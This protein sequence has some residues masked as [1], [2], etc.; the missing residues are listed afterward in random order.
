M[1]VCGWFTPWKKSSDKPRQCIKKQRCHF[2]NKGLYSPSYG[3]SIVL[4]RRE[5]LTIKKAE[6]WRTDALGQLGDQTLK[7]VNLE[8]WCWSWS[9]ET[10]ATW[11]EDLTH[12]NRPWCWERLKA[13]GEGAIEEDK[14]VEWH[15]WLNRRKS[16][17][18]PG[19]GEG[20]GS[21]VCFSS[22]WG[23]KESDTT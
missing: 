11:W 13:G 8:Y 7:K 17:Q 21:P 22:P 1:A 12:W 5:S 6:C 3:F 23:C 10:L 2:A 16:E 14:M 9:S 4:Y 15:Q 19:D 20:Q 18:M